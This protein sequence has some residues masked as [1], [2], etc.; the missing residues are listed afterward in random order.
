[1]EL[2][3][4]I[5]LHDLCSWLGLYY[6]GDPEHL[7]TGFNEIHKVRNGDLT[8]VDHPKYYDNALN[9]AAS[10][11]LM[12]QE[13]TPPPGKA[14]VMADDPFSVFNQLVGYYRLTESAP[15]SPNYYKGSNVSL[16]RQVQLFPGVYLG[17]HV[18]I[19]DHTIIYPN[20]V[21]Y[22]GTQ[23]GS[24]VIIHANTTLGGDAFYFKDRK[25]YHDK[26]LSGGRVVV[27]DHVEIGASCSIDR[28]VSG[29]TRIGYGTKIDGQVHIGHGVE[30]G[31]RC[32]IAAQVGIGGK[33]ILEDD[34][35]LW[36]QVGLNK[37]I[38]LGRGAVVQ[39]SSAVRK[40]IPGNEAYFGIP[41]KPTNQAYRELAAIRK[42]P[43]LQKDIE[44]RLQQQDGQKKGR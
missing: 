25:A 16:G 6:K 19:G 39:A 14:L 35:K 21:I 24:H 1:M 2:P 10:T 34:V 18:S 27:E 36:G 42:L 38:R 15:E 26:L 41:A 43:A 13:R 7:I 11:I 12:D 37:S 23:I 31:R 20:T 33:T 22:S 8:F 29:Q 17:D 40:S 44:K 4:P 32:I 28:G 5:T 9:S 30:I 3:S